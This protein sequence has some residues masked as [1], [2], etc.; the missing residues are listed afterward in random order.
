M[1]RKQWIL[2]GVFIVLGLGATQAADPETAAGETLLLRHP[3]VSATHV[4]FQYAGDIWIAPRTGGTARR[5]TVHE[6]LETR[7]RFS[8]DGRW[9]AFSGDYDGN[10]DVYLLPAE[11]GTPKRLTYHPADDWVEGWSPDGKK[12]LFSS[13]RESLN[14]RARR[15]HCVPVAG[16][17][18]ETLP[19]PMAEHGAFSPD[20][21]RLAY[22]PLRDAFRTWKRYR[23]GQT[24]PI[25]LLDLKTLDYVEIP[26]ERA[27]DTYPVWLGNT[28]YFLSDR[29]G[30][31][32][33]FAYSTRTKRVRQ[34][35]HHTDYDVKYVSGG[36]GVLVYEQAGRIHLYNPQDGSTRTLRI[37]VAADLPHARP[38][39]VKV[40][41]QIRSASLSPTGV[42]AVFE[43]RGDIFTVPAKKGDPRNLTQT[44]A[45]HE[46]SPA[47]SPD[48]RQIA[49]FSD[50][51][52][53]YQLVLRDQM[54]TGPLQVISPGEPDY[55]HS[56]KW[57]PD[58]KKILYQR[59]RHK[60]Y[61][62]DM[63]ERKPV[64]VVTDLYLLNSRLSPVWS[65]DSRWIA[66]TRRLDNNLAA[67]FVY[68]LAS[69]KSHQVTDGL[70]EVGSPAFSRDGQYLY[71]SA[72]TNL[73]P[74]VGWAGMAAFEHRTQNNLYLIV[75]RK[76]K[77]TPFAPESDEEAVKA[78]PDKK[79][80]EPADSKK[81]DG[82]K[83]GA[84]PAKKAPE[85]PT[86]PVSVK[87][88]FENIAQRIVALPLPARNYSNLQVASDG[89]LF[90]LERGEGT[91]GTSLQRFDLKERKSRLF[92]DRVT[93]YTLSA[94]GKSLLYS[95]AGGGWAIT[96]A[97]TDPKP[98][99]G[100][101]NLDG[102]EAYVDPP[103]EW[104]QIFDEAWRI[105]RD[106]FY[107]PTM[108]GAD[109]PAVREKY[110]KF[111]P[112]VGHRDDL[113]YLLAEML[114][115]M[116]VGHAYITGE[117]DMPR[118][119][120]V[121]VGLLGADF[122]TSGSF[123]RFK[124]IY[125]GENWNP[126]LRAPLTEPGVEVREGDW[127]LEVNGRPLRLPTNVFS[128]FEKTA[129]RQT[130]LMVNSRPT[131]AGARTVTVVP[132]ASDAALRH[133]AWIEDNRRKVHELSD[134]KVGYVYV[135]DTGTS[136]YAYFIRYFFAQL[137]RDAMVVD[138]RFN[139][140]GKAADFII[141]TLGRSLVCYW[142]MREG[143]PWT[144]PNAFIAGPK[145]MLINE[146][147]GSGGDLMPYY[148]RQQGLGKLVG[149]RTW[150]GLIGISSYPV[151]MDG[152]VITAPCFAVYSPEGKWI[153]ENEGVEPDIEVEWTPKLFAQGR[154][155]QLEKAVEVV[156]KELA[157]RPVKRATPP[158]YPARAKK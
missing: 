158:P 34:I 66:Y 115:E 111:L 8:P 95:M 87:I 148:F 154:D 74:D 88:D 63:G 120:N 9:I 25:W 18:E 105:E 147:A 150:G 156:L 112:H 37:R 118:T 94:D 79:K 97:I 117:G 40:A 20:G 73:G 121:P 122:E 91:A 16:G 78:E 141:E 144:T 151:L 3:T 89:K 125:S 149:K 99:E 55:Y 23:G 36:D 67:L 57:S 157:R 114:G 46:R 2:T 1:M 130:R 139:G 68:E 48:G 17:F 133:R 32:N 15:L 76:D 39:F 138:E 10:T 52:G 53:E 146:Y 82:E 100:R 35:T 81:A 5:L 28:V 21:A 140:G 143:R 108:H 24:T 109:W 107:D 13:T 129:D 90:Y 7:P 44:P 128:L 29:N 77:P 56:P 51:G 101:L 84:S 86:P 119:P 27:S 19:M 12:V 103:A 14:R 134:G 64:L 45:V 43:A 153:I 72:S 54:G 70:A 110:R 85:K 41:D 69:G 80:V 113:N 152:G 61:Y 60:L 42:R 47:W 6:G 135:P 116:V 98:G 58:G 22:T 123:Y 31:M 33:L 65:P 131:S 155:P 11:G 106:Y 49:Y 102:M 93:G 137:D 96:S 83:S 104:G 92:L 75:L 30:V 142:A 127:L 71:F 38:R 126:D 124:R 145:V 136:G 132:V 59:N 50:A 26:H 62:M 4:A